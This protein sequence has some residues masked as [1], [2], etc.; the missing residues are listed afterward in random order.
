MEAK[1][2]MASTKRCWITF[3]V[4]LILVPGARGQSGSTRLLAKTEKPAARATTTTEEEV[5]ALRETLAA[6]H[7]EIEELKSTMQRLLQMMQQTTAAR[8]PGNGQLALTGAVGNAA[9]SNAAPGATPESAVSG[10][11]EAEMA[12]R[13]QADE[14]RL[15]ELE[16]P[17]QIHFR[18]VTIT[19]GGFLAANTVFRLHNENADV[20][21]TY[22]NVPFSGSANSRLSEFRFTARHS[23]LSA[24]F[25]GKIHD[26]KASGYY[27][28]DFEGAAPTANQVQTN[29]FQPRIRQLWAQVEM[30]NGFSFQGGQAWSL[31]T[32]NRRGISPTTLFIPLTLSASY[33][34]GHTYARQAGFRVTK[35]FN[36]KAWL[37]F[38]VENPETVLSAQP[39]SGT[40]FTNVFANVLGFSN[41]PNAASP[42]SGFVPGA[43]G[44]S[45]N[46]GPDLIAKLAFEPG[47]GHYELKL[48]GRF[49]RDRFSGNNDVTGGGGVGVAMILPVIAKKFD[50]VIQGLGGRGIGRYGT[51]NGSDVTM[52]PDTTIVPILSY[53][54]L[55]GLEFHP[56][57]KWDWWLYGGNEYFG[58]AA[59]TT[60]SGTTTI[61]VGYGSRFNNLS[62]CNLEIPSSTQRCD[63]QNRDVWQIQP[64]FWY[65][66]WKGKEGTVQYGMSYSYVHR[67]AWAGTVGTSVGVSNPVGINNIVMTSLRY[68]FP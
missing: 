42:S 50:L 60:T 24:L 49:F 62:G 43:T 54:T 41:S 6:Q 23:R 27:E 34:V 28:M 15:T 63:A 40:F 18:G 25:E 55:I 67:R 61:G 66:F 11:T 44:L 13:M 56:T 36:D 22:G 31:L 64:G 45:T 2:N 57:P 51:A 48:L 59:Y 32:S 12:A 39:T 8:A 38:A 46:L 16:H 35:N 58:R 65:R 47:W 10:T 20:L 1:P 17:A 3:L 68:Y 7:M 19:P 29:S 52:R 53:Q 9:A 37:A 33:N 26:W 4:L 30:K 14:K 21:D 5:Q